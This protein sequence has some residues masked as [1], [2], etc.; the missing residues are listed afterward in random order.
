MTVADL[1]EILRNAS[2]LDLMLMLDKLHKMGY[3]KLRWLSYMSPNGCALRCH[4]TTAENIFCNCEV[5]QWGDYLFSISVGSFKKE[6]DIEKLAVAFLNTFPRLALLGKGKDSRYRIWFKELLVRAKKGAVPEYYGEFWDIPLGFIKVG[7][8]IFPAPPGCI[9][10][11][12]WNIDGLKAK[13]S[14]LQ[15]LVSKYSPDV[16]C[17]QK[18]KHAGEALNIDGYKCY[19]SSAPYA[20]V[21]TYVRNNIPAEFD[22]KIQGVPTTMGY[23]QKFKIL[24][25]NMTLFNCYVPYSNPDVVGVVEHRQTFD[26]LLLKQ[27]RKTADRIVICGDMN[28]VHDTADCWDGKFKRN[29]ANFHD[30]ERRNFERLLDEGNLADTFRE[31]HRSDRRFSYFFRNDPKVRANNQGHRIDYFLASKSFIPYIAEAEI[32]QDITTSTNNPILLTINF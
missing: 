26:K 23:L 13:W 25:L 5:I 3:E 30:W 27:V 4:L 29:Q 32:I 20:G 16:I 1:P 14:S 22:S 11:I 17:L 18:V 7:N 12:S 15:E 28:I 31:F 8:D 21:C 24:H 2:G 6:S 19:L 9:K 10:L